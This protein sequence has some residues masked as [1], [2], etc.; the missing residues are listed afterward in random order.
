AQGALERAKGEAPPPSSSAVVYLHAQFM[1]EGLDGFRGICDILLGRHAR[2]ADVLTGV[3]AHAGS[4][5]RHAVILTDLGAALMGLGEFAEASA[6]LAQAHRVCTKHD[7]PMGLQRIYGV[8]EQFPKLSAGLA[9]VQ[10]LDE[11]LRRA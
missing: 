1:N 8:R 2:A 11:R 4:P 6:R 10:E 7:R 3:F 9:C 5:G